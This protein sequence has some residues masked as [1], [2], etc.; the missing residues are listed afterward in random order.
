MKMKLLVGFLI[1]LIVINLAT[2]GSF[3]YFQWRNRPLVDPLNGLSRQVPPLEQQLTPGQLE[4]LA[5]LVDQ[6]R[7][8]T[9]I[10]SEKLHAREEILFN[11]M[12]KNPLPKDSV[13]ATVEEIGRMRGEIGKRAVDR[14]I[15]TNQI[16]TPAQQE[17]FFRAIMSPGRRPQP[18]PPRGTGP[19]D[20]G[21]PPM[22]MGPPPGG[23]PPGGPP[24][25]GL[26]AQ[27]EGRPID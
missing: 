3:L 27:G 9:R 23:P 20:R 13:Y 10:A 6:F 21:G 19:D 12:R 1:F 17:L 26:P 5:T 4:K 25:G 15:E 14:L 2:I 11:M 22:R 8:D 18:G 24:P 7:E 16:L